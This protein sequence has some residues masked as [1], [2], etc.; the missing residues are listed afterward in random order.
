[1]VYAKIHGLL[2]LAQ[3]FEPKL[4]SNYLYY[5]LLK[6]KFFYIAVSIPQDCSKH[7]SLYSLADLFNGTPSRLLWGEPSD[8][9]TNA[10][11]LFVHKY[12]P[13]PIARYSIIELSEL[14]KCR[15]K[16]LAQ[17]LTRQH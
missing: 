14:E 17:G 9:A 13:L 5:Y 12:P 10:R 15:V 4:L 7:F 8:A 6:D 16:E 1:M 2:S 3:L 11:K